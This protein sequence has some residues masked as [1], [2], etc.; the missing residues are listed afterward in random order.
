MFEPFVASYSAGLTPNPDVS[1]NRSIKFKSLL[2]HVINVLK[3]DYL[4]TGH[5]CQLHQVIGGDD[6][7]IDSASN[8]SSGPPVLLLGRGLDQHKDQSYFLSTTT[9]KQLSRVIFPL[10]YMYAGRQSV[11]VRAVRVVVSVLESLSVLVYVR[12]SVA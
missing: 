10:V 9:T 4:A 7:C 2:N 8:I 12:V 5:Y 1:C 3:F 11:S 6:K